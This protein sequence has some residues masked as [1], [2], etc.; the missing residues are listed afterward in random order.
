MVLIVFS[1]KIV[2]RLN[3]FF[4]NGKEVFLILKKTPI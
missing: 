4:Y 3:N 1:I 2:F